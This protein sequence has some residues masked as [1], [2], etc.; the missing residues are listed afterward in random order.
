MSRS[1]VHDQDRHEKTMPTNSV[2]SGSQNPAIRPGDDENY[3]P[4]GKQ[5]QIRHSNA[6][7]KRALRDFSTGIIRS[8]GKASIISNETGNVDE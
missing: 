1:S 2:L 4:E 8:H 5:R 7:E 6:T 3:S